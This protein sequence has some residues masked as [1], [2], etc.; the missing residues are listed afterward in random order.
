MIPSAAMAA[1]SKKIP[2]HL[3]CKLDDRTIEVNLSQKLNSN[4]DF[5]YKVEF[6]LGTANFGFCTYKIDNEL[7]A[8]RSAS[9]N[10]QLFISM[11]SCKF[12]SEKQSK[13]LIFAD[14]G[15]ISYSIKEHGI[16]DI[17]EKHKPLKCSFKK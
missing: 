4:T 17:L 2:P 14:K 11:Q 7:N 16:L 15:V 12:F 1:S 6:F 3:V 5:V 10:N 9:P 13:D 8:E